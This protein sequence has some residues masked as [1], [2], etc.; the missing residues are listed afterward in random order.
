MHA[1]SLF[2]EGA[3][4]A[5]ESTKGWVRDA[6][7][8]YLGGEHLWSLFI[9][10]IFPRFLSFGELECWNKHRLKLGSM[11]NSVSTGTLVSLLNEQCWQR[12]YHPGVL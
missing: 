8:L 11:T 2:V 3:L 1:L 10:E 9:D 7:M 5:A 4:S 12:G 6:L